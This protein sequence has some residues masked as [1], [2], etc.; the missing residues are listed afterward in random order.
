MKPEKKLG[1]IAGCVLTFLAL[2]GTEPV[3]GVMACAAIAFFAA[4][5]Y[6]E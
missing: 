3:I 6:D 2:I 1:I 4:A 5:T